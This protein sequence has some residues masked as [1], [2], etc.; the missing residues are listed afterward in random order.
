MN[1][2]DW[3]RSL[4][5]RLAEFLHMLQVPGQPGR[6]LP[7]VD[8]LT[9]E[10]EQAELG[11]SCFA[12][13][14]YYT[15]GLWEKLPSEEQ[16]A[17]IAFLKSYQ[18]DGKSG[19]DR[20]THNAFIDRPVI[21]YLTS[22]VPA[23]HRFIDRF[24]R[25]NQLTYVQR[26]I[27]A[28]TKQA[29]ATLAQVGERAKRPYRG[30]PF[31]AADVRDHLWRFDWTRPWGAGGQAS[32]LVV[33]LKTHAPKFLGHAEVHELLD[34]CVQFFKSLADLQTGAYFRGNVPG[35]GELINGAMKVL[36][37]LDWLEMP[38]H[39]PERL[40]DTCLARLPSPDGCHLVDGVYVLYRCLQQ[41]PYKETKIQD[42]CAEVLA[43]IKQ[44]HNPDGGFS[45]N[46][47]RSGTHYYGVPISRGLAESDVHG[48]CL[49]A[50]A[51]AMILEILESNV[52][53]WRVIRP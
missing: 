33:F 46:I 13:K 35:H 17:W 26:V 1:Q 14:I 12:M 38:I 4:R 36:T 41:T 34:T 21:S 44:H 8:G 11:F 10:G 27:I 40:I 20:V 49:L 30:F 18:V 25:H 50:W 23:Y 24:F 51:V 47:G 31:T 45:Y 39:Y 32:A 7:C 52:A 22:Q 19:G 28:E 37:A 43:M 3:V 5:D 42:Y 16:E 6:F 48:T 9:E 29:T 2:A 53:G 15:L